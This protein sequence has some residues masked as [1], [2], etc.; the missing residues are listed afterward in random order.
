M[1][2]VTNGLVAMMVL[3][4]NRLHADANEFAGMSSCVS[5]VSLAFI[6]VGY[7][8]AFK[9]LFGPVTGFDSAVLLCLRAVCTVVVILS[10]GVVRDG[11]TDHCTGHHAGQTYLP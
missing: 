9:L 8:I 7:L 6:T 10:S 1:L 11:G 3:F 5:G 2:G 4:G